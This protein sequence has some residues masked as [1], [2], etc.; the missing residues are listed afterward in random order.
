MKKKRKKNNQ[1]IQKQ[2]SLETISKGILVNGKYITF[3]EYKKRFLNE[4][5]E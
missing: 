2:V 3:Q 4:K 5:K 1:K